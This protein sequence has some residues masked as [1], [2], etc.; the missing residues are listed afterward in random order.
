MPNPIAVF[1]TTMGKIR[2]EIYQEQM[3]ITASNF[4]DL[5]NTGFY[6]G[7]HFHRVISGFMCQ[8]GCPY[9]KDPADE[10]AGTGGPADG[11]CFTNLKDGSTVSRAGGTIPD[12]F[13]A[14]I[15]ND[16]G[17]LSMAN[18]GEPDS[19]GSQIFLNVNDN[20][21]LNWYTPGES[22]HTVF[23]KCVDEESFNVLV[24]I[25]QVP[26]R[27]NRPVTPVEVTSVQVGLPSGAAAPASATASAAVPTPPIP[28]APEASASRDPPPEPRAAEPLAPSVVG[29]RMLLSELPG[30]PE[31][32]GRE[33]VVERFD[34]GTGIFGVRLQRD[35]GARGEMVIAQQENLRPA[36]E[37]DAAGAAAAAGIGW[38]DKESR[39]WK[40]QDIWKKQPMQA[41][42]QSMV[43]PGTTLTPGAAPAAG[44]TPQAP[45]AETDTP[46]EDGKTKQDDEEGGL[47]E[48]LFNFGK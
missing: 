18:N 33:V 3:P 27:N 44:E 45:A 13:T 1:D 42:V 11:S 15:R 41:Y 20:N 6:N 23:G 32:S 48:K 40:N 14:K 17:S 4:I 16:A 24:A 36:P 31:L 7:L 21:F 2:C 10:R 25:S 9:S 29:M 38:A 30:R 35:D 47:F 8:F 5:V 39:D 43:D 26:T 34:A 12:E 37:G 46:G 19:G 28:T 22:K